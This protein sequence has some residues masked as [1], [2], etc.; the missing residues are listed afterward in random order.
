MFFAIRNAVR[1]YRLDNGHSG[2]FRMDSPATP[3]NIRL[4]CKDEILDKVI[5]IAKISINTWL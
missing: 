1:A 5:L 4:A 3:E 2:Y